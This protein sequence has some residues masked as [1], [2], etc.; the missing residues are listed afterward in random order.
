MTATLL[1]RESISN[2]IRA[3]FPFEV[4]RFPLVGPDNVPTPHHGLFRDDNFEC[5]GNAVKEGYHPHTVDD[6]CALAEAGADAFNGAAEVNATWNE[7]HYLTIAPSKDYQRS[8]WDERHGNGGAHHINRQSDIIVPR[9]IIHA[10]YNGRS[11]KATFGLH[12]LI[13][14]NLLAIP[15]QGKL[16]EV[17]IRHTKAL[18]E[19][20]PDIIADFNKVI[21]RTDEVL[22]AVNEANSKPIDMAEFLREVYPLDEDA[23]DRKRRSHEERIETIMRRLHSENKVLGNIVHNNGRHIPDHRRASAWRAFNAVQGFVQH[24]SRRHNKPSNI[25]RE[26]LA[27]NDKAVDRAR[28]LAF[29]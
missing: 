4:K 28:E 18:R 10:G 11:F 24:D 20:M 14:R 8:V 26:I 19:R 15:V 21:G 17:D 9:L 16:V 1:S 5:V 12:R 25:Q 6:I 2:Q 27:L 13:C 7:G 3:A 29:A 23:T 22:D